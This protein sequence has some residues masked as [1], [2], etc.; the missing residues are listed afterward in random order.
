ME[1][2]HLGHMGTPGFYGDV[3]AP[4]NYS[5][6]KSSFLQWGEGEA[7]LLSLPGQWNTPTMI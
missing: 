3:G 4:L 7:T 6:T 2:L 5:T 1:A